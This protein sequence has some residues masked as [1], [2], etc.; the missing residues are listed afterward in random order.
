VNKEKIF[1]TPIL[2]RDVQMQK[3]FPDGKTFLDCLPK[4]DTEEINKKYLQKKDEPGF[5]LKK[6]VADH[7][8]LPVLLS[9][10]YSSN[11]NKTLKENIEMLWPF[12]TRQ[13]DKE[14][15]SLIPLPYPY[16]V[17]GGRFGEI[18]YWD[19]YFTMLGLK[20]SGKNEMIENMVNNF[21][22]LVD[23]FGYIPN[24]NR[25][26]FIGR[27]QPPFF[28][29]MVQLLASVKTSEILI[30]C[31]PQLVKEYN[32]WMKGAD[33]LSATNTTLYHTVQMPGGEV[34]NRYWD[35]NE[36]PRPES[37]REDVELS[38]Q[39]DQESK[40]LFRHLRA[41]AESGWDY[42]SRWFK[43]TNSFAS[44]HTIDIVPVDLNC[45]VFHLEKTIAEAYQLKGNVEMALKYELLA[46]KR[47]DAIQKYF[48]DKNKS[49]YFDY[50]VEQ[51]KQTQSLTLAGVFPLFI[52]IATSAQ[53]KLV[54]TIIREKFLRPGGLVSTLE[55]TGQQWDAPNGWAPLQWTTIT[56]LDNY[57][58]AELANEI[59]KQWVQLNADVFKRTGKLME[60]YNV[61]DTNLKA[62]G[63]EYTGQDGFGWTNGV[64]LALIQKYGQPD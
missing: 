16:I 47:E 12:L 51:N 1:D 31:L 30:S 27:S 20:V 11:V 19:S 49:Y 33:Q 60:K 59:A 8:E 39:S 32:F 46:V 7:F 25:K 4:D 26:Y 6:F 2:L 61:V 21:S 40:K 23:R 50:D 15:G 56:G 52:K 5:N 29:H 48:W 22:Y 43:K 36:T 34:L 55:T 53:A 17:P 24:G 13:P 41:G 9:N 35:E 14:N 10:G 44:I 45:L 42:S 58:H 57:G 18:Y 63:G 37:L 64:L 28:S 38:L 62:G 54:A 3:V